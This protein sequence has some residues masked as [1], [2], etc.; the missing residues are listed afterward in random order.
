MRK[1]P[2]PER[3]GQEPQGSWAAAAAL[4]PHECVPRNPDLAG[5]GR[6]RAPT[7]ELIAWTAGVVVPS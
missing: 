1:V 6:P 4:P 2:E 3:R 5:C 7:A